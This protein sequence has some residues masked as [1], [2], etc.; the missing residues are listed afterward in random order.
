M[1]RKR[2]SF[3]TTSCFSSF[4]TI[5]NA[6]RSTKRGRLGS[7]S[8]LASEKMCTVIP[9]SNS[10]SSDLTD[11]CG[12]SPLTS[13]TNT[14]FSFP[15]AAAPSCSSSPV[16][17]LLQEVG[18]RKD[19]SVL[20]G[21]ES[22]MRDIQSFLD[23]EKSR[24]LYVCGRPGAGKSACAK[25]VIKDFSKAVFLNCMSLGTV[26]LL[27]RTLENE[28]SIVVSR[29]NPRRSKQRPWSSFGVGEGAAAAD[30]EDY[31]D[32]DSD[33]EAEEE[34]SGPRCSQSAKKGFRIVVLDEIDDLIR[35]DRARMHEWIADV[36]NMHGSLVKFIGISNSVDLVERFLPNLVQS[37]VIHR[38]VFDPYS[39]DKIQRIVSS[40]YLAEHPGAI[41]PEALELLARR[42]MNSSGDFRKVLDILV[43][44][45]KL[46]LSEDP[47]TRSVTLPS[48]RKALSTVL[49]SSTLS[50]IQKLTLFQKML[51]ATIIRRVTRL[52]STRNHLPNPHLQQQPLLLSSAGWVPTEAVRVEYMMHMEEQ[53]VGGFCRKEFGDALMALED[54][55]VVQVAR[56][57]D[58]ICVTCDI[59]DVRAA[60]QDHALAR[61]L[62]EA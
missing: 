51:L 9:D 60:L 42:V 20:I 36:Y 44:S 50:T 40:S 35:K 49:A 13:S 33:A 21:R 52:S 14:S 2:A 10:V 57:R 46:A 3:D 29:C 16:K 11:Y 54:H 24:F 25:L 41:A 17:R 45:C 37:H 27:K 4:Q 61:Q 62:L 43:Q 6:F 53:S 55:C 1:S 28:H 58:S 39:A 23:N 8:S 32:I 59:Q 38:I 5:T 26:A 7:A 30:Q 19:P 22:E 12:Q 56:D 18:M 34:G 48:M 31:S 47:D 15:A